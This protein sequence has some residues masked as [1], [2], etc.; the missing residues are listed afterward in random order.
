[1][2]YETSDQR[3]QVPRVLESAE[4]KAD[5]R[6]PRA[7]LVSPPSPHANGTYGERVKARKEL[8]LALPGPDDRLARVNADT[9]TRLDA[10]G[11][12]LPPFELFIARIFSAIR[13]NAGSRDSFNAEFARERK[14][15][16]RLVKA[17]DRDLLGKRVLI[18]RARG[19]EDSSRHWS[20]L[21]TLDHLRIVHGSM[22]R[23][24]GELT[25]GRQ[26]AGTA[27]TANVKPSPDVTLEVIEAYEAS[28]DAL[29]ATVA[30]A[31][32]LK[33]KLRFAHPWFGG[34]DAKGW[35]A[36]AAGHLGIHRVQIQ[37]IIPGLK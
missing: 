6:Q 3:L 1:M 14:E 2:V 20:V 30:T 4:A 9:E 21:M 11:A 25:N 13:R 24:I 15:I 35:H 31:P 7:K 18:A 8:L 26:P 10:P 37:R 23:I 5:V 32:D 22:S 27:S 34:L 17:C 16:Q 33:T 19:M 36:L 12:G 28:C 29:L